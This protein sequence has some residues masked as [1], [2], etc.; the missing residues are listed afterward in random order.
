MPPARSSITASTIQM[1]KKAASK[2]AQDD[3]LL[4]RIERLSYLLDASIRIPGIGYR[5]GYDA[6]IGLIPGIGDAT[7]LVLS[8]YIILEAARLGARP[9]TLFRMILNV[10]IETILGA[11][12]FIGDL[13]DAVFK[14]NL[15]NIALLKAHAAPET[16]RVASNRRYFITIGLVLAL[17]IV[18]MLALIYVVILA[19]LDLLGIV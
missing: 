2:I 11:I 6:L 17:V 7:T 14:A 1:A 12:P 13:F 9:A 15:R 8:S 10:L 18:L 16:Y 4:Q 5:I 19:L 3:P